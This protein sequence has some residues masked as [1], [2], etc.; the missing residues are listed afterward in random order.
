MDFKEIIGSVEKF[1]D[2]FKIENNY[3]PTVALSVAEKELRFNLMKEE[4]EEYLEAATANDL[5][6]RADARG[7]QFYILCQII[8]SKFEI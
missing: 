3:E 2:A 4:N 1:H 6:E 7:D 5:T 8:L